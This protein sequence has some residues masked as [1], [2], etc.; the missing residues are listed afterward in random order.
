MIALLLARNASTILLSESVGNA[1]IKIALACSASIDSSFRILISMI[2]S[3]GDTNP[4]IVPCAH[5][6]PANFRV[7]ER[8]KCSI[9]G[10]VWIGMNALAASYVYDCA[11]FNIE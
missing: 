5:K 6:H 8:D 7:F 4:G 2:I 3:V 11:F 10:P 9:R 1:A